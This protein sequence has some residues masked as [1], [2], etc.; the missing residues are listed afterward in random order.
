M[1]RKADGKRS[2]VISRVF[3]ALQSVFSEP[4]FIWTLRARRGLLA[5]PAAGSCRKITG[6]RNFLRSWWKSTPYQQCNLVK[7]NPPE[8][9]LLYSRR[10]ETRSRVS[11]RPASAGN[12]RVRQL[13]LFF[14]ALGISENDWESATYWGFWINFSKEANSQCRIPRTVSIV[15]C[16]QV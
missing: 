14:A 8:E 11:P 13:K 12:L 4:F 1:D 9:K 3:C 2:M 10:A 6:F 15:R 7:F 16:K 5:L